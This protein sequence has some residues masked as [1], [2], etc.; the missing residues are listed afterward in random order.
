[1]SSASLQH[2]DGM[3]LCQKVNEVAVIGLPDEYWGERVVA[4]IVCESKVVEDALKK[5]C[6][7]Y[8]GKY[9]IPK[10]WCVVDEIPKSALGKTLK[11]KLRELIEI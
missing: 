10:E 7:A 11:T 6:E 1:M 5:H 9:K 4:V 8:L 3:I 2:C